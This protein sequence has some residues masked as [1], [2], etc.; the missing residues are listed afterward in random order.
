M[1]VETVLDELEN[2]GVDGLQLALSYHV[3]SFVTPRNPRSRVRHGGPGTVSLRL[4]KRARGILPTVD[5]AAADA[6]PSILRGAADRHIQ[7]IAWLVF[8]YN[9]DLASRYPHLAVRNA[10][11]D[12]HPAQLCPSQAAV[13]EYVLEVTS[14]ALEL[15]AENGGVTG[16]HAES[17]SFLPWDYGLTG[18]KAAV[19]V[20]RPTGRLLSLCFCSACRR[21]AQRA[22][23]DPDRLATKARA[24]VDTGLAEGE[25]SIDQVTSDVAAYE[26]QMDDAT[27]E[28]NHE[29]YELTRAND[30]RFSTTAA[31]A[32]M[33]DLEPTSPS[34]V[35]PLVD[36]VRV[37]VGPGA[38][39]EELAA[40]TDTGLAGCR[41]GT[42]V[43][44]QYQLH[45][46]PGFE[47]LA[48]A[49]S[50]ASAAGIEHHRFYEHSVLAERHMEWLRQVRRLVPA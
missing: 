48:H 8:L 2:M 29:V 20:D 11:G 25:Q 27:F 41:P 30:V 1:G 17:L 12:A 40:L 18:L 35:R 44:A 42:H 24:R 4:G 32:H 36:E 49:I 15:G 21:R 26:A 43:F 13:R 22:D 23:M 45:R 47:G 33:T 6:V 31:E 9:H 28:V 19:T 34:S 39:A 16:L 7:V 14:K 10:F 46:F 37:K 5:E 3:A 38:T 50:A